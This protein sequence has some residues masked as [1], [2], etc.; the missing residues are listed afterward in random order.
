MRLGNGLIGKLDIF[1]L[2]VFYSRHKHTSIYMAN[3]IALG[4]F[5]LKN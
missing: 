1:I 4:D 5:I 2:Q 3:V